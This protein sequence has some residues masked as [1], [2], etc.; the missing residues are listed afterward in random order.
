MSTSPTAARSIRCVSTRLGL[1][2][3]GC[4]CLDVLVRMADVWD[5]PRPDQDA[6]LCL[7]ESSHE[8]I[9]D[10]G[11]E[12][13]AEL[14]LREEHGP[15]EPSKHRKVDRS[16][17]AV[18]LLVEKRRGIEDERLAKLDRELRPGSR[19][20]GDGFHELTRTRLHPP[21][22]QRVEHGT[23][24]F[25]SGEQQGALSRIVKQPEEG[26]SWTSSVRKR[27]GLAAVSRRT[28]APPNELPRM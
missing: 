12:R 27:S 13:L 3:E 8:P 5:M 18:S 25:V 20:E 9:D 14:A 11:E 7:G 15:R 26:G 21:R 6:T 2:D 23:D 24:P 19:P 28:I 22:F 4:Y 1:S 10:C 17:F 16:R